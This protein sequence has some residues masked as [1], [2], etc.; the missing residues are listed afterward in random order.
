MTWR[1]R[2]AI[3]EA[4]SLTS[5]DRY[6]DYG[7]RIYTVHQD[8]VA[9]AEVL[10]GRPRVRASRVETFGGVFDCRAGRW[11]D[12]SAN[13]VVW[14]L[15]EEQRRLVLHAD[16]APDKILC[17][18]AEGAGKTRGVLAPWMVLQAIRFAGQNVEIGGTAPTEKRLETL[19]L[20]LAERMPPDWFVWRQ[21][22]WLF[23]LHLGVSFRLVS[24]HRGSEA[25]GSPVQGYDWV[26][27]GADEG[28]DQLQIMDDIE[29]R[30]R[31]APGGRYRRMIA[32]SAKYSPAY[33][34]FE[35][36]WAKTPLC[37]VERIDAFQNPFTS[38]QHWR[39][40]RHTLSER[41][42]ARRV[43]AR[44]LAPER[45]TYP[46]WSHAEN[47][48]PVPRIGAEDVT[49]EILAPWG[50]NRRVLVGHDPGT[51][52]DVSLVLKAYRLHGQRRHFWW[53]VDE[54]TT[55]QTTTD[56]HVAVLLDR[57]QR[58]WH[59]N[60]VDWRGNASEHGARA[61]VRADPHSNS[62]SDAS[63][64]HRSVYTTFRAAG[65]QILPGATKS[66][67]GESKTDRVPK[68][69]GIE[70]VNGLF[71][72][73]A[74][75][76]RLF[77]AANDDGSYAAPKLVSAIEGSERDL[78]GDAETQAKNKADLS[79]WPAS[80]RYALWALERPRMESAA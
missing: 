21:R 35:D 39:N 64:P 77:V 73:K 71:L 44:L 63:Q 24:A 56:Q 57:L 17:R 58:R 18:A 79:H 12:E 30:G 14:Y 46:A 3:R 33:R 36:K 7:V 19:R 25:E 31:R 1:L 40:L 72:N 80:L 4:E 16:D 5:R 9:G 53:V 70:M 34:E 20:A 11:H 65:L 47:I 67:G 62:S 75:E 10:A 68:D 32:V 13:P 60:Q 76:R 59:C 29:A 66:V 78:Y 61:L 15:S 38:Q 26:A 55:E 42:Y 48:R 43:E 8:D 41:E 51:L 2:T 27:A 22:D 54:I 69:A 49:A 28:Q 50:A 37:K 74:K 45:A 52:F 23:R 6:V